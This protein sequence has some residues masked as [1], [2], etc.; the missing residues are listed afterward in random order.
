MTSTT[1]APLSPEHCITRARGH[2]VILDSDLAALYD[3]PVKRLNEQVRRNRKRFPDDFVFHLSAA[4]WNSLRSQSATLKRGAHRKY[5]P[6]VFTEHGAIMAANV[7]NS[8]R[9]VEMSV[10]VVRAFV[11]LRRMALSVEGLAR[12]INSLE[13]KYDRQFKVVFDAVRRLMGDP[14]SA[15]QI[16]GFQSCKK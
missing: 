9:A 7:L 10:A 16:D 3:V 14:P 6:L 2:A 1:I 15:K 13:S 11:K 12:K 8:E 4:E 5:L